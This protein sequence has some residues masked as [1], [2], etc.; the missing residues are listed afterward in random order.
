[1]DT[2]DLLDALQAER[3]VR[4]PPEELGALLADATV[5]YEAD[6]H[7]AG[8]LRVLRLGDAAVFQEE[9]PDE[10]V[11]LL[12]RMESVEAARELA[13]DRLETYDRMWD[14]CGCKVDYEG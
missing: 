11:L 9:H 7:M 2:K 1:M 10:H 5:E 8:K 12:R 4:R 3:V 14:G 6:T 13:R